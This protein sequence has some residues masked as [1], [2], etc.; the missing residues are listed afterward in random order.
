M[1]LVSDD[2]IGVERPWEEKRH[3]GGFEEFFLTHKQ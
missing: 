2:W 1:L 3:L